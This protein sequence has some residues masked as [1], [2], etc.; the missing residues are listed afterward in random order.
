MAES[1]EDHRGKRDFS[2]GF[3][4]K[5]QRPAAPGITFSAIGHRPVKWVISRHAI[6]S[7]ANG[8]S[9]HGSQGGEPF[10][11][12]KRSEVPGVREAGLDGRACRS[13]RQFHRMS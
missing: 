11:F 8:R 1:R 7:S 12:D 5:V 2:L 3:R 10:D 9:G 13:E 4:I 6:G